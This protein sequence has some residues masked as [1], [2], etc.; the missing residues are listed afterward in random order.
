MMPAF[1]LRDARE[2]E[3]AAYVNDIHLPTEPPK[4]LDD[5]SVIAITAG[6]LYPFGRFELS[7]NIRT[8]TPSGRAMFQMMGVFAEFV[9]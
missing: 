1:T 9:P 6:A 5:A 3:A 8:S 2:G 4:L 7:P